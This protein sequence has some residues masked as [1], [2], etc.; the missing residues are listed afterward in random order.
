IVY[1]DN[2]GRTW[3]LG[4]GGRPLENAPN[5]SSLSHGFVEDK[6]WVAVNHIKYN[7]YQDHVYAAWAVYNGQTTKIHLAVSGDRAQ[8][9]GKQVTVTRPAETGSVNEYVYPTVDVNG[10]LYLSIASNSPKGNQ[11]VIYVARSTDDA[12]T[13]GPWIAATPP[14]PSLTVTVPP[15]C[16][17]NAD[18]L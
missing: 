11:K 7:K 12:S 4:N 1:S 9:F 16:S 17:L 6:Q 8:S 10:D 2:L 18:F 14:I 5:W 15:D 3:H 13:F